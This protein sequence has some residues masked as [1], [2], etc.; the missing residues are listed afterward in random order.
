MFVDTHCHLNNKDL[1]AK[2]KQVMDEAMQNGVGLFIVPGFDLE[3]SKIAVRL[4]EK[5]ENVYAAIG[6]HPNNVLEYNQEVESLLREAKEN[7]KV[8]A[9]GEIGLDYFHNKDNKQKQIEVFESQIE[10]A[11]KY[12]LP[13]VIHC[14]DAFGD[15]LNILKCYRTRV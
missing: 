3:T 11:N 9:I 10:L 6:I 2:Y 12:K 7:K 13:I 1:Y 5:Y 4:A 14:R 8:V 15:M